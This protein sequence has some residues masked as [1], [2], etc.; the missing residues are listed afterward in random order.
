MAGYWPTSVRSSHYIMVRNRYSST[1][2]RP[3]AKTN[4]YLALAIAY[5][6]PILAFSNTRCRRRSLQLLAFRV[7]LRQAATSNSLGWLAFNS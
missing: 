2:R 1:L 3:A 4:D 5:I 7:G 6:P